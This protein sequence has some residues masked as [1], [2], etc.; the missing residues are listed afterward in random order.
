MTRTQSHPA[1]YW[2]V[3]LLWLA[4][5]IAFAATGRLA[6]LAPPV[7]QLI[8]G[9][10]T[11]ALIL[12]GALLPGFRVWLAGLNIR[13]II[14][15]HV[16]RFVGIWFL[17][18]GAR[19]ELAASFATPAGWGDIA[20]AAAALAITLFVPDLYAHRGIVV[21]WNL[22]GLA[23]LILAVATA[24][25]AALADRASMAPIVHLPL[26]IV[27]LFLVP[28]LFASHVLLFFRVRKEPEPG[29]A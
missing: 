4:G 29:P 19:G 6:E 16:L 7:P 17:I 8:V 9:A 20:V 10:L 5:A 22:L 1:L 13:Q 26:A 12:A 11:V 24:S 21:G 23:D 27:P 18:L 3:A 14:F 25:R 2:I 28:L 15:F